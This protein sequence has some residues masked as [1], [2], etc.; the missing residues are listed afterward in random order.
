MSLAWVWGEALR[1]FQRK[2][3]HPMEELIMNSAISW[4]ALVA[5]VCQKLGEPLQALELF[6][7]ATNEGCACRAM[8]LF[9]QGRAK[10][11]SNSSD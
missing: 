4:E 1:D 9:Q 6:T 7:A 11:T 2:V 3:E 10:N 5:E 8:A